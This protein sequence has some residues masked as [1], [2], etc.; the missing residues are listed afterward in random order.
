[1]LVLCF[2][3]CDTVEISDPWYFAPPIPP[4]AATSVPFDDLTLEV[5]DSVVVESI[6]TL[7]TDHIP[8]SFTV[9][10]SD[11]IVLGASVREAV[12]LTI[13]AR[14]PGSADVSVTATEPSPDPNR[15]AGVGPQGRSA[16]RTAKVTVIDP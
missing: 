8:M 14:R 5:G 7:F 9:S 16:T 13:T 2:G 10:S 4:P 3:S 1:M 12:R 11:T 6:R 15:P